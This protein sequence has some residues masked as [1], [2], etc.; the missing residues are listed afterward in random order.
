MRQGNYGYVAG[1]G[2]GVARGW[3]RASRQLQTCPRAFKGGV[4]IREVLAVAHV[5]HLGP[6]LGCQQHI[7]GLQVS[8]HNAPFMQS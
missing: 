7:V 8:V 5:R 2:Q 6:L 1:A 3:G 4:L